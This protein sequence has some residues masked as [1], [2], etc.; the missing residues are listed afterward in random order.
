M[1]PSF[2]SH[3]RYTIV[4][5]EIEFVVITLNRCISPKFI[6]SLQIYIF[7]RVFLVENLLCP[8]KWEKTVLPSF[9]CS[10][11]KWYWP[12]T[13][14]LRQLGEGK[15]SGL[16]SWRQCVAFLICFLLGPTACCRPSPG[17]FF[18]KLPPNVVFFRVHLLYETRNGNVSVDR[19]RH[20][21]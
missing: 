6:S 12:H 15:M 3:A 2:T 18:R 7:F 20:E 11:L 9:L 21:T 10:D 4:L 19:R 16:I 8:N 1:L 14:K 13:R 5:N 17:L